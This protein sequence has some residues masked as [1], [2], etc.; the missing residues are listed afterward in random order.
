MTIEQFE[1]YDPRRKNT[2]PMKQAA[3]PSIN[4]GFNSNVQLQKDTTIK[5]M[6][7]PIPISHIRFDS[8]FMW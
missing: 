7:I 3:F 4:L 6:Y 2:Y 1:M 5:L 8:S